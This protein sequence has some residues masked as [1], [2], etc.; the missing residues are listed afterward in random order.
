[1]E[2]PDRRTRASA[3][4]PLI[5][6]G[7]E[8]GIRSTRALMKGTARS[9]ICASVINALLPVALPVQTEEN[10]LITVYVCGSNR[11]ER[12]TAEIHDFGRPGPAFSSSVCSS[13]T[14]R[15]SPDSNSSANI[16]RRSRGRSHRSARVSS[17]RGQRGRSLIFRMT[18]RMSCSV[19]FSDTY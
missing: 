19:W 16:S 5:Q 3:S 13:S 17:Y 2:S 11:Q 6:L 14:I 10:S 8:S 15:I 12:L 18:F 4:S 7:S 9:M 1:M